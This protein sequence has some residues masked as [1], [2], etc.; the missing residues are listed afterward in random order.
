MNE[1]IITSL[2]FGDIKE[3]MFLKFSSEDKLMQHITKMS[4]DHNFL[5]TKLDFINRYLTL[6]TED[7]VTMYLNIKRLNDDVLSNE[8]EHIFKIRRN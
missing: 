1:Y 6:S 4:Q 7:G 8:M 2:T 3:E 5:P